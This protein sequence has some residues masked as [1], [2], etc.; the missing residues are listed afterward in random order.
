MEF[1]EIKFQDAAT[2]A[3]LGS[4]SILRLADG[5]L[6]ATH[7]YFGAGAPRTME[8]EWGLA[9][10]Y[11]SEDDGKSWTEVNHIMGCFWGS[12]F[13]HRGA[14]YLLSVSQEY[15]S[16]V[17]RRS[18]DRGDSWTHP[19]D[20]HTGLLFAGG[21]YR[22]DP[23][24]HT[25]PVP[26]LWS[27][28]RIYRGFEDCWGARWP[29]G[30]HSL[31][32]SVDEDADLLEAG[33]W[34]MSNKLGFDPAWAPASWQAPTPGW[35]EG[36]VVETPNGEIWNLLRV[37]STPA[38]DVAAVVKVHDEGRRVTFDP[39]T[40]FIH[41]PGGMTKFEI[42]RDPQTG[43]YLSLSNNNTDPTWAA[44]RNVLSLYASDDLLHWRHVQ[45][46][47]EDDQD[48]PWEESLRF[49]A[50]QYVDWQFDGDD[51]IYMSRTAYKGAHNYHDAN[52]MT[53]HK[54]E[55]FRS[56]L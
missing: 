20:S 25:S 37:N 31:V 38:V 34:R 5:A 53:F 15:G 8:H 45:T 26:M 18:D 14:I 4:P 47:L 44:Q 33:N 50:F 1:N 22:S 11:R 6:V 39:E 56:L 32:I 29:Q 17:I 40:G 9:S 27:G 46:L 49:T 41:F 30:F 52:H 7:D 16:L 54:I 2:K 13:E 10:V 3:Y 28:G 35:L 12:L 19:R 42:R 23:N 48:I 24:Y 55:G 51:I 36:N 43:L 21:A